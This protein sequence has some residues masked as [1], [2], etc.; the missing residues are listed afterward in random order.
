M[1]K[2]TDLKF[3]YPSSKTKTKDSTLFAFPDI[4]CARKEALLILGPSGC[5]KTTL[6]H[7][8]S[9]LLTPQQGRIEIGQTP[10]NTLSAAGLDQ[11]R[12]QHIGLV[13][14]KPHL[15]SALTI[16]QNLLLAQN[17]AGMPQNAAQIAKLLEQL[18]LSHRANAKPQALSQGE[19]QRATIARAVLN[20]PQLLLADEPTAHLDDANCYAV[21]HL[22][23]NHAHNANAALVIVTHDTRLKSIFTNQLLLA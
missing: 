14:Q 20:R 21:A 22:L 1:L 3:S 10:I 12:G 9:G 7:L 17:L 2:T 15:I 5:G 18:Q 8:L 19:Q 16:T 13:F 4:F 23:K 6:L 11:F